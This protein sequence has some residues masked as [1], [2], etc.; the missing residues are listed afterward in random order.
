[1]DVVIQTTYK[2]RVIDYLAANGDNETL[3]KIQ[4]F[5]QLTAKDIHE[6]ERI[7]FEE[8]D[9]KVEYNKLTEGHPYSL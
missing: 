9:T 8:L 2:Q 7:L 5:E 1:M 4:H 3:R 6:L